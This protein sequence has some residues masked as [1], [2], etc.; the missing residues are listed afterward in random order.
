MLIKLRLRNGCFTGR[1]KGANEEI[2]KQIYNLFAKR[3]KECGIFLE[4]YAANLYFSKENV[5]PVENINDFNFTVKNIEDAEIII[6]DSAISVIGDVD[7]L[8]KLFCQVRA[9]DMLFDD[10]I[11]SICSY[12]FF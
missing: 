5:F 11:S 1:C 7:R 2:E 4:E 6:N 12:A 3:A 8:I 9:E 10:Y